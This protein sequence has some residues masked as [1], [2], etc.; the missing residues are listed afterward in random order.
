MILFGD[1]VFVEIR[2]RVRSLGW[3]VLQFDVRTK[4]MCAHRH[5]QRAGDHPQAEERGLGQVLS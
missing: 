3:A 4:G 2:V 1:K 5:R